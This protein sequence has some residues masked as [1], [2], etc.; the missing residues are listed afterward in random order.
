MSR[1]G[2]DCNAWRRAATLRE[3]RPSG[4]TAIPAGRRSVERGEQV[5]YSRGRLAYKSKSGPEK[6][7]PILLAAG[8]SRR[9]PFPKALAPFGHKT[10]LEIAVD[11]CAGY[12]RPI[13]VLGCQAQRIRK[14][15]PAGV[16]LVLNRRWRRGQL[17]SLLAA[18]RLVARD[19]PFLVYPVDHPLLT[20]S[21]VRRMCRAFARRRRGQKI[22]LPVYR[23]RV[24]HPAIFAPEIR[25]ELRRAR[26]AREVVHRD[27]RRVNFVKIKSPG[28][29]LD[30]DTTASYRRCLR[31]FKAR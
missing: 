5:V 30:F 16:R 15:V 12:E 7:V 4:R 14:A 18:L 29:W 20:A 3:L 11:N 8:P 21:I 26:T 24:G 9:L 1:P 31:A 27:L 2:C 17:S 25:E 6:I 19:A 28:I 10:A 13:V 23:G 22:A